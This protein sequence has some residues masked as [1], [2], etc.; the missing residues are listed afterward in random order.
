M[1][2]KIETYIGF[3]I[4]KGSAV[5]G[6]DGIERAKKRMF[7][8]LYT[9]TLSQNSLEVLQRWSTRVKCPIAQI[10]DFEILIKRNCKAIAICDK[11][12]ADAICKNLVI[13]GR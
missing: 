4:K 2:S 6:C 3:A 1:N 5:F 8:I 7:L 12:L 10:D 9:P 13:A 11:S